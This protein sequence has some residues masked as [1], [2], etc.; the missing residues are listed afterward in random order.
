MPKCQNLEAENSQTNPR[1]KHPV[2]PIV[3]RPVVQYLLPKNDLRAFSI[4][5][6]YHFRCVLQGLGWKRDG[7]WLTLKIGANTPVPRY[8]RLSIRRTNNS[9]PYS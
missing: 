6:I 8:Q 1:G 2:N 9:L 7:G 4:Y 3:A 5:A